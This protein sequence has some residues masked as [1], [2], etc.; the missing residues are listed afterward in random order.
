MAV[1]SEKRVSSIGFENGKLL[2]FRCAFHGRSLA[3]NRSILSNG[4]PDTLDPC[5]KSSRSSNVEIQLPSFPFGCYTNPLA[6]ATPALAGRGAPACG[7]DVREARAYVPP[8]SGMAQDLS[9]VQARLSGS[10][11]ASAL[12][13][14]LL[15]N[16]LLRMCIHSRTRRLLRRRLLRSYPVNRTANESRSERL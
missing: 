9:G 8:R 7:D 12:E 1:W 13:P 11:R 6:Q 10:E 15:C 4:R 3:Q 2:N 5:L 16:W 14:F